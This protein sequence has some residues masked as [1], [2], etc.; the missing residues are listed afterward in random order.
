MENQSQTVHYKKVKL[1]NIN[2]PT[3]KRSLSQEM[4]LNYDFKELN[5]IPLYKIYY[6]KNHKNKLNSSNKVLSSIEGF[7]ITKMS[8]IDFNS[9]FNRKRNKNISSDKRIYKKGN[10]KDNNPLKGTVGILLKKFYQFDKKYK[11]QSELSQKTIDIGDKDL[12]LTNDFLKES[13]K[14]SYCC[15]RHDYKR[16]YSQ[17]YHRIKNMNENNKIF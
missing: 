15:S 10:N 5:T 4:L 11:L 16:Q 3:K 17:L 14:Y 7:N 2:M 8:Y 13:S 6:N 1:P 9:I 12:K